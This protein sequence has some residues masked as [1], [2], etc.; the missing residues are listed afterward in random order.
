MRG[1]RPALE[2]EALA[3]ELAREPR[4]QRLQR[5]GRF[6]RADPD[7]AVLAPVVTL[8]NRELMRAPGDAKRGTHRFRRVGFAEEGEREVDLRFV[9]RATAGQ[10]LRVPRPGGQQTRCLRGRPQSE[11]EAH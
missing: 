11:E 8:L 6:A 10:L 1:E 5:F 2:G 4:M 9:G 3:L 7:D